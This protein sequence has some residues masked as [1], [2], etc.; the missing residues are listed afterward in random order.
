MLILQFAGILALASHALGKLEKAVICPGVDFAHVD[1]DL[2]AVLPK[3][4]YT[5]TKWP[6]GK[7]PKYCK[8][9]AQQAN[10][11]TYDMDVYDATYE[12]CARPWAICHHHEALMPVEVVAANFGRVPV[13]L[14]NYIRTQF[15][16]PMFKDNAIGACT[17]YPKGDVTIYGNTTTRLQDWV[18]EAVHGVDFYRGHEKY[19]KM[20]TDT[21]L[22][23]NEF[24]K[25]DFISDDYAKLSHREDFAQMGV[26]TA[27]EDLS[28]GRMLTFQP[29][30]DLLS[31]QY[32]AVSSFLGDDLT[33]GGTC[34]RIEED[35]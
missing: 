27:I 26:L 24:N 16:G 33:R 6:W 2:D 17:T 22:W 32:K 25:D 5:L 11:S 9:A 23:L 7:V 34:D 31:H 18:H 30:W 8:I 28:P 19:G 35:E 15:V 4:T 10:L 13:G 29:N 1:D 14:R 3:A 20:Y 12:D 21:D